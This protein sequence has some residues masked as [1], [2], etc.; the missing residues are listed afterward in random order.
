MGKKSLIKSTSKKKKNTIKKQSDNASVKKKAVPKSKKVTLKELLFRKFELKTVDKPYVRPQQETINNIAPPFISAE[1]EDEI[2]RIKALLFQKF[3]IKAIKVAAEKVAAEK[4][5]AEKAAAEKAVAEKAA[6]EKAAAEKAAAEN[7]VVSFDPPKQ[8]KESE[9]VDKS[10]KILAAG[11]VAILIMI[12]IASF[13]N[14]SNYYLK[15]D[16]NGVEIWQGKFAP[17][18]EKLLIALPGIKAP[19]MI[20]ETYSKKELFPMAFNYQLNKADSLIHEAEIPDLQKNKELLNQAMTFSTDRK[21]RDAVQSRLDNIK[22]LIAVSKAD[23]SALKK[24]EKVVK[25]KKTAVKEKKISTKEKA[26][27]QEKK[28]GH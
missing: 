10:I 14:S 2:K 3:D 28:S 20:K 17:L 1:S 22:H 23:L 21:S 12:V 25:T 7:V 6:A 4:A 8:Q 15:T 19:E 27:K 13:S 24:K 5:A 11:V 16:K 26:N 9:P 18:G